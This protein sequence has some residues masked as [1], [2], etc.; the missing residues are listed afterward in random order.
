MSEVGKV[1]ASAWPCR[2]RWG[3]CS[4]PDCVQLEAGELD[5]VFLHQ[6]A[7]D[8][9][10]RGLG[11]LGEGE[12]KLPDIP[13]SDLAGEA[14]PTVCVWPQDPRKGLEQSDTNSSRPHHSQGGDSPARRAPLEGDRPSTCVPPSAGLQFPASPQ[15]YSNKPIT[16]F[17][18]R[19]GP[20]CPQLPTAPTGSLC[21]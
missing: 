14:A 6:P 9:G 5:S 16:R 3:P 17:C 15:N 13:L 4:D 8:R 1:P 7:L 11:G 10:P 2:E 21:T 20:P 12:C 19:L 18:A